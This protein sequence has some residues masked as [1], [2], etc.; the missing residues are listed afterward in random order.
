VFRLVLSFYA[1]RG[2][3]CA[4]AAHRCHD[5]QLF[6]DF[7]ERGSLREPLESVEHGLFISHEPILR[8]PKTQRKRRQ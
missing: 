8:H 6:G 7:L 2:N 4:S 1:A 5:A 3:V